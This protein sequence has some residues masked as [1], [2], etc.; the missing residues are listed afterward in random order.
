M[1]RCPNPN[2][3]ASHRELLWTANHCSK[4]IHQ[5][6][7]NIDIDEDDCIVVETKGSKV[8]KRSAGLAGSSDPADAGASALS[9]EA[10]KRA[11][12]EGK[13]WTRVTR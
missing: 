5:R 3:N 7:M 12:D 13:G 4:V 6:D 8:G 2:P 1:S 11:V 10:G 9:L